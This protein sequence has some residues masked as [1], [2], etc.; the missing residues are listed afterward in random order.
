MADPLDA[1]ALLAAAEA[2]TGLCDWGDATFRD[3][4]ARA[5]ELIRSANMDAAGQ[6]IAA[7]NI[8]W[9][10]SDRLR[11]FDDHVKY[12]LDTEVIE[13]PMFVTGEPRSGTT[14]LHA[15]LSV[16]PDAR[17]LRFWEVMHPSPPPGPGRAGRS[18]S[19]A[20]RRRMARDQRTPAELAAQPP[21]QRHAGRRPARGRAHLGL[22]LS[23]ADA[24]RL[25]ARADGD[26]RRRPAHRTRPRST[27]STG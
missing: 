17:A 27:A 25:V 16:D 7:A 11:F 13:R 2:D 4:F 14:L 1:D 15:L 18:A 24:D 3:R 8:H 19:R 9:L 6:R 23:R 10:L 26:G 20:G 12:G 21:L 5:V 22:R